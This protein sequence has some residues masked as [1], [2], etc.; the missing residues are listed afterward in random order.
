[1]PRRMVWFG[2]EPDGLRLDAHA[3][4]RRGAGGDHVA[5]L[6]A[7]ELAEIGDEVRDAE[8]HGL[9]RAVLVA[10]AVDFEPHLEVL[11]I[12]DFVGGDEPRADRAEGVG[13]LALVPLAAALG[14]EVALAHVVDDAVAGDVVEG[15]LFVDVLGGSCR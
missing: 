14:L 12:G 2:F 5:R 4:A 11:R 1:M 9:G 6:Q 8:D 13:R 7:H 10:V 3:D 15:V